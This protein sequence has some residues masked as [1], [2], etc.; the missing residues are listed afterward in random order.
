MSS[1]AAPSDGTNVNERTPLLDAGQQGQKKPT[2]LP[3]L[4]ISIVLLA[5][6][7]E[8]IAEKYIYPYINQLVS[9]LDIT[10]SDERKVGEL[11]TFLN[12]AKFKQ[13]LFFATEALTVLY[14]SRTS[15][16]I[17]RKPVLLVGIF[18]LSLSMICFGLSKTFWALALS[19]C[20]TGAFNGNIGVMKGIMM[21]EL[22]DSTNIAQGFSLIPI[23]WS[24]GSTMGYVPLT[25]ILCRS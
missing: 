7:V 11:F 10:G 13:S 22:T 19:R 21:G 15:D 12:E 6:L 23:A 8:A 1:S 20:I 4:Q 9:E 16:R 17:G 5:L 18:G 14:W 25:R 24:A 2:P 3:K